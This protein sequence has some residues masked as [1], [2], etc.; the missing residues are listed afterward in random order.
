MSEID[1]VG[2]EY[3]PRSAPKDQGTGGR[4]WLFALLIAPTA[5]TANGIIQGGVIAY[6]LSQRGIGSGEQSRL[7]FLLALPTMIYSSGVR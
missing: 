7:I 6:M 1:A 5:V 4:P 2:E 3:V